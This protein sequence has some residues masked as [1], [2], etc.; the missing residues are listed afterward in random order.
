[1]SDTRH[2]LSTGQPLGSGRLGSA[3][4]TVEVG[5]RSPAHHLRLD[6]IN[7]AWPVVIEQLLATSVGIADVAIAGRLGPSALAGAGVGLQI[8]SIAINGL[9]AFAIGTTVA[10]AQSVGAR[11]P[12]L[13]G[14]AMRQGVSLGVLCSIAVVLPALLFTGP[15]IAFGGGTGEVAIAGEQFLS[16]AVLGIV[17]L[18]VQL[19]IGGAMRGAGD[20]RTP[21]IAGALVNAVNIAAAYAL[22]FGAWGAPNLGIA[23]TAWGANIA[24]IVGLVFLFAVLF[25]RAAPEG[26]RLG[27]DA[28]AGTTG[29]LPDLSMARMFVRLSLPPVIEQ[30]SS[31]LML[32]LFGR[33]LLALGPLV[34][35]GWR[36]TFS[37]VV[38]TFLAAN[39]LATAT[40]ALV[41]QAVGAGDHDRV[42]EITKFSLVLGFTWMVASAIMVAIFAPTVASFFTTDQALI[43]IT[44]G[45]LYGF[46]PSMPVS[47]INNMILGALR[48]TGDTRFPMWVGIGKAWCIMLPMSWYFSTYLGWGLMGACGGLLAGEVVSASCAVWRYRQRRWTTQSG[49]PVLGDEGFVSAH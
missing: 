27:P 10:V 14:N 12:A 38:V 15:L 44:A 42:G 9:G 29:W 48:G 22:A 18:T 30:V 3:G 16:V 13:A 39:G 5:S 41:G 49:V 40:T 23:G 36:I 8:L 26:I 25:R 47:A 24:R 1:M 37:T 46:V 34:F 11:R 4:A 45:G 20:S 33:I 43:A 7:L 28:P 17:P 19:A 31:A 6:V 32:L 21:M 2:P 35:A